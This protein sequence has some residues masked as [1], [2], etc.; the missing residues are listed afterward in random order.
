M[1]IFHAVTKEGSR[2]LYL[3]H[4]CEQRTRKQGKSASILKNFI[5]GRKTFH[6]CIPLGKEVTPNKLGEEEISSVSGWEGQRLNS[7]IYSI[8]RLVFKKLHF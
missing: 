4:K 7:H 8:L 3:S 6:C 1:G 2:T 5:S